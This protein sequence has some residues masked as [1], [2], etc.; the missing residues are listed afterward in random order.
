MYRATGVPVDRRDIRDIDRARL[1][2]VSDREERVIGIGARAPV[3]PEGAARRVRE[4][5]DE[6]VGSI[7]GAAYAHEGQR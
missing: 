3:H 5:T 1:R 6:V 7:D 2:R 4:I